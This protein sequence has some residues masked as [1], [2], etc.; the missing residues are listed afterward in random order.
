LKDGK[1]EILI[2]AYKFPPVSGAG[3][4]RISKLCRSLNTSTEFRPVVVTI[5]LSDA[6]LRGYPLDESLLIQLGDIEIVR[7]S[8][9]EPVELR[10]KL[11][12]LHLFRPFWYLF[13][14]WFWDDGAKWA[15]TS[16]A[17]CCELIRERNIELV[18]STSPSFATLKLASALRNSLNVKWIADL[19]DPY[20]QGYGRAWPSKLHWFWSRRMER[21]FL[22]LADHVVVVTP[23]MKKMYLRENLVAEKKISVITNG[24]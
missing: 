20:T 11:I 14:H 7:L 5:E 17:K 6:R 9:P 12:R 16:Y 10:N 24:Y 21:R 19:R 23:E 1:K 22:S 2:L 3:V 8:S 15:D 18:I 13:F 4:Y